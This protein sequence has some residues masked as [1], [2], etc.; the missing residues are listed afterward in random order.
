[1]HNINLAKEWLVFAEKSLETAK[2]LYRE[3]HYTDVIAVD[4]HQT[5]EKSFKAVYAYN[6][7][8]IPRV[9]ALEVLY[10]YVSE[11]INFRDIDTKDIMIISDYY[12]TERYPG[13]RY[14]MPD[15]DEIKKSMLMAENIMY[16]IRKF[17][18]LGG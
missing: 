18:E 12:M 2:L 11:Y 16:Q 14:F 5:I 7:I 17:I 10:H 6:G 15:R 9:H 4:I 13:P 1:M 8:K 3:N